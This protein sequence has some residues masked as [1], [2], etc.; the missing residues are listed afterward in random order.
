MKNKQLLVLALCFISLG[1]IVLLAYLLLRPM[2]TSTDISKSGT[3]AEEKVE[4]MAPSDWKQYT[5]AQAGYTIAYPP[6]GIGPTSENIEC[7]KA[8]VEE[9]TELGHQVSFENFFGIISADDYSSVE[10]YLTKNNMP[11]LKL[12]PIMIKGADEAFLNTTEPQ[13]NSGPISLKY[14]MRKGTTIVRIDGN[15]GVLEGCFEPK[16][17][18]FE[19]NFTFGN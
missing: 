13:E 6:M 19:K 15:N 1:V 2:S 16:D 10:D 5:N 11:Q 4:Y 8:I 9:R 14:I 7:G 3:G 17:W 18:E 12:Y